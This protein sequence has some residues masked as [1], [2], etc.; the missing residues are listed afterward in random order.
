MIFPSKSNQQSL[1][2]SPYG[3]GDQW[4]CT[5]RVGKMKNFWLGFNKLL[6]ISSRFDMQFYQF[7]LRCC[8]WISHFSFRLQLKTQKQ[9]SRDENFVSVCRIFWKGK[10]VLQ[11]IPFRRRFYIEFIHCHGYD[12]FLHHKGWFSH[13][14]WAWEPAQI[15]FW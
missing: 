2:H 12:S 8:K 6:P 14:A 15:W 10:M 9:N 4:K 7:Q 3:S 13:V 1:N 11:W 5:C